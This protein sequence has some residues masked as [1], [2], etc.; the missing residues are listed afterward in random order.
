M[1]GSSSASQPVVC[2]R[3]L[4]G[5]GCGD[6]LCIL[7]LQPGKAGRRRERGRETI[8]T[9]RGGG[10]TKSSFS[11]SP[12]SGRDVYAQHVCG[13]RSSRR[14]RQLVTAPPDRPSHCAEREADQLPRG[15]LTFTLRQHWAGQPAGHEHARH[16]PREHAELPGKVPS[17]WLMHG[18]LLCHRAACTRAP[19][20]WVPHFET[21]SLQQRPIT[22]QREWWTVWCVF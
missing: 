11:P 13:N 12:S 18:A 8:I 9:Q 16:R 15:S 6:A 14:R 1:L 21:L 19:N 22:V 4:I 10:F 20:S 3:A 17:K 2:L 7:L 5:W